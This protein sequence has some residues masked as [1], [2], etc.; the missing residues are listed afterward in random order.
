MTK[1]RCFCIKAKAKQKI[2]ITITEW[3][4]IK[5][6]FEVSYKAGAHRRNNLIAGD[7]KKTF[8]SNKKQKMC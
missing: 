3:F 1:A 2:N 6:E 7:K 4:Q 8:D 5:M